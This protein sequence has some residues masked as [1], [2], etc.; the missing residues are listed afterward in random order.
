MKRRKLG[1]AGLEVSAI[2]IG[3][4]GMT[5]TYGPID[6][7]EA[8]R[9]VHEAIERGVTLFD[10]AETYGPFTNE[11]FV[12]RALE[13]RRDRV[14]L[15]TKIG[16]RY[17]DGAGTGQGFTT[18][19]VLDGSPA[20]VMRAVEG[21]LARLRT[22]RIDLLYIH[23]VDP[24]TP[25]EETV[26]AMD[27]LVRD[28][29]VRYIG[30]SEAAPDTIRR[31]HAVHPVSVLQSEY[32]LWERTPETTVFALLD[33]LGIGFVPYCPLGRGFLSG[34]ARRAEAY[35]EGDYRRLDPRFQGENFDRNMAIVARV[36]A[37]AQARGVSAARFALAWLLHRG[38][39]IVP[40]PGTERREFLLDNLGA[41]TLEL[42][43]AELAALEEA[44]PAGAVSGERWPAFW[45]K[46]LD[47]NAAAR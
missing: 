17:P 37:I 20:R 34:S 35:S 2:G 39:H 44:A 22:D 8:L 11:S 36:R 12:G 4:M 30:L 1:S 42:S 45:K 31:A 27:R 14:V 33:E 18:E 21:S 23:R 46:H 9:T 10:T 24:N 38:E 15:A 40:I 26:G 47:H 43:A 7:D 6:A 3:C 16:Y 13:G 32:S 5:G 19:K 25:I 29:K 41:T 28:G